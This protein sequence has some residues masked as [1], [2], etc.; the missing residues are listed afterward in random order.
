MTVQFVPLLCWTASRKKPTRKG[1]HFSRAAPGANQQ[2]R[3]AL[4]ST[5]F[6]SWWRFGKIDISDT[7][8]GQNVLR[9]R[10]LRVFRRHPR[11]GGRSPGQVR[12]AG[13]AAV[14]RA[15]EGSGRGHVSA[16]S[17]RTSTR[18][19]GPQGPRVA[20]SANDKTTLYSSHLTAGRPQ[21]S[22]G[23]QAD[24]VRRG[25]AARLLAPPAGRDGRHASRKPAGSSSIIDARRQTYASRRRRPRRAKGP[26]QRTRPRSRPWDPRPQ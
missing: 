23:R 18:G 13:R 20:V 21:P 10:P 19:S 25:L 7:S 16:E 6:R 26:A 24:A 4:L 14:R 1:S 5:R 15:G 12:E 11:V 3:T 17:C 22:A 8:A 2:P 9:H